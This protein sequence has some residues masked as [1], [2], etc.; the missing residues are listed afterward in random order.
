MID[1][2]ACTK[3]TLCWLNC[4]DSSFDVTPDGLYDNDLEACSGCGICEQVCPVPNCI[5]MVSE[6]QFTDNTSQWAAFKKNKAAY[7]AVVAAKSAMSVPLEERSHGYRYKGQYKEQI[8]AA[9]EV[10][11]KG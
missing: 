5:T 7:K 11:N 8:P 3:C 10:A 9:L 1:F 2:E 6:H 4:P